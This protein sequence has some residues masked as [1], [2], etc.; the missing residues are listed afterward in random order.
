M[1][2]FQLVRPLQGIGLPGGAAMGFAEGV[3]LT[4]RPDWL[5]SIAGLSAFDTHEVELCHA[6]LMVTYDYPPP[7]LAIDELMKLN[8]QDVA[9]KQS[10]RLTRAQ[11]S[12]WLSW[13]GAYRS[14]FT[15]TGR[16]QG[17]LVLPEQTTWGTP[18]WGHPKDPTSGP[19]HEQIERAIALHRSMESIPSGS[20]VLTALATTW[21]A[22]HQ[23]DP[24]VRL[25]LLWIALE[26]LFG[27]V[28]ARELSYRLAQRI[29]LFS[30]VGQQEAREAFEIAKRGYAFRSKVA[31]G[32]K[33][34]GGLAVD[35]IAQAERL[36]RVC[37]GRILET[38]EMV[39]NFSSK[40]REPFLD[41][42][43]FSRGTG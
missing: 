9:Q 16:I 43:V 25:L 14:P 23:S 31:H 27:P 42:L 5:S 15:A 13:P 37:L 18:F 7:G 22:L 8:Q 39:A 4:P 1:T 33:L 36:L 24:P 26:S 17:D 30:E 2:T 29:A 34:E 40:K 6:A 41:G 28:D 20:A 11:L 38:E 32:K 3:R 35:E 19:G 10:E 12:L 21:S